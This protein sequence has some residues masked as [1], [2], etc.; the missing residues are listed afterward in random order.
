MVH[1]SYYAPFPFALNIVEVDHIAFSWDEYCT[2]CG[3]TQ[4]MVG[5]PAACTYQG[6]PVLPEPDVAMASEETTTPAGPTMAAPAAPK[7]GSKGKN[8]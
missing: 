5:D 3:A 6:K 4:Q 1:S 2:K 8:S 7:N